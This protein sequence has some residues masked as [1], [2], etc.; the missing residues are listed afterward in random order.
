MKNCLLIIVVI[1]TYSCQIGTRKVTKPDRVEVGKGQSSEKKYSF[2]LKGVF[3]INDSFQLFYSSKE[4]EYFSQENS[5]FFDIIGS[6]LEQSVKFDLPK[7]VRPL[8]IRLD[9]GTRLT[10]KAI[11]INKFTIRNEIDF[12]EIRYNKLEAYLTP[13][14]NLEKKN[15]FSNAYYLVIDNDSGI[16]DPCLTSTEGLNNILKFFG[17]N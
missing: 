11:K 5:V 4:N 6:D 12:F 1:I 8:K 13:N 16:Y 9:L 7:D 14:R 2:C 10:S 15:E 17:K 3:P